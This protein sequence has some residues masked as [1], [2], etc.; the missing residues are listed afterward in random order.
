MKKMLVL[1]L[2]ASLLTTACSTVVQITTQPPGADVEI[3]GQAKG[4][5]PLT[6]PLSD[7]IGSTYQT[8]FK[9]DGY[10]E[11]YVELQKEFKAGTFVGGLFVWP[12]L[13]WSYGPEAT[14]NF[15]LEKEK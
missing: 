4:K 15:V 2:I 12:F 5:T 10:R 6:L 14:Q 9:M 8:R 7:F 3:N 1:L 13:L 11:K